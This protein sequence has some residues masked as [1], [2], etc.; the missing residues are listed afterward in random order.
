M[1]ADVAY[2]VRTGRLTK[3]V[4]VKDLNGSFLLTGSFASNR[5]FK[6]GDEWKEEASYF[7][8]K[9]WAKNQKQVDFYTKYLKKGAQI[10]IDGTINQEHWEKDG[11]KQSAYVFVANRIVPAFASN[12][13]SNE[14]SSGSSGVPSFDSNE[15]FPEDIEF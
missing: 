4:E 1:S 12:G 2:D 5:S 15:G 14:H 9:L 13:T 11:Q 8:Y 10:T 7:N 3:N 6:K